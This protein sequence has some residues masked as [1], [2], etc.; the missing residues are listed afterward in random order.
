MRKR[1]S[2]FQHALAALAMLFSLSVFSQVTET[3]ELQG[4]FKAF[5]KSESPDTNLIL[6][7][8]SNLNSLDELDGFKLIGKE[9]ALNLN[10]EFI[11]FHTFDI[12]N[13]IGRVVY[14]ITD[15]PNKQSNWVSLYFDVANNFTRLKK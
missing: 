9:G 8:G 5:V 1:L 4:L 15:D 6:D 3:S 11:L 13:N 2:S 12:Q 7:H 14:T 10:R